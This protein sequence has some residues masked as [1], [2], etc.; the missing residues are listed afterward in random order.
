MIAGGLVISLSKSTSSSQT[1]L[2]QSFKLA[3]KDHI[4]LFL[5]ENII[6]TTYQRSEY[7]G[8]WRSVPH[9]WSGGGRVVVNIHHVTDTSLSEVQRLFRFV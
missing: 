8:V 6:F 9:V 4:I 2:E 5:A 3:E 1:L 7:I